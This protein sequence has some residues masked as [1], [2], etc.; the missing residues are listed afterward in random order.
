MRFSSNT[1]VA[2]VFAF[3]VVCLAFSADDTQAETL[4]PV[5]FGNVY[6]SSPFDGVP[7]VVTGAPFIGSNSTFRDRA[8]FE[9]DLSS[10]PSGTVLSASLT[11]RVV[12]NNSNNTGTRVHV[13]DVYSGDGVV[14]LN[15]YNIPGTTVGT[16]SH[17]SGFSTSFNYNVVSSL[18]NLLDNSASHLGVRISAGAD[19]QGYDVLDQTGAPP[20]LNYTIQAPTTFLRNLFPEFDVQGETPAG[21]A[22]SFVEGSNAIVV[23]RSATGGTDRRGLLEFDVSDI[24]VGAQIHSAS[25][26]MQIFS[27]TQSGSQFSEPSFY[28]YAG[29][30]I[31]SVNDLLQTDNFIGIADPI[32]VGGELSIELDPNYIES[33]LGTTDHVG[34]LSVGN[35]NGQSMQFWSWEARSFAVP[36]FLSLIYSEPESNGDFD[37]DTDVDGA[38]F[39][40]W[41]RGESPQSL[42]S[43]DLG[44]WEENFG[45]G[46]NPVG[47][48]QIS[49]PEP[50]ATMMLLIGVIASFL[51]QRRRI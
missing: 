37:N 9:F 15:D 2:G 36:P 4:S 29:D 48:A 20:E 43:A 3:L 23:R 49:V 27:F 5:V 45:D 7:N 42:S 13:V 1:A 6:D 46:V 30:G 10:I 41:Q 32:N 31:P 47:A 25:I 18:Q 44:T 50:S 51:R 40:A 24:P 39:L 26:N 35:P 21:G 22:A 28:G 34:L 11:G 14:G 38:D 8:F 16:F 17:P 12:P 19:P 33:L